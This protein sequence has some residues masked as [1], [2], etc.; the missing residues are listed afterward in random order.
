MGRYISL[1]S[2]PAWFDT[3]VN[4]MSLNFSFKN[5]FFHTQLEFILL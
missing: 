5:L 4:T 1:S 2:I 3:W